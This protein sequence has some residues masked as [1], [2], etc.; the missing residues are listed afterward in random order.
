MQKPN[1][2]GWFF[3]KIFFQNRKKYDWSFGEEGVAVV[4]GW[5]VSVG[6]VNVLNIHTLTNNFGVFR[7]HFEFRILHI[8]AQ[9]IW[10]KQLSNLSLKN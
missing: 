10:R 9:K 3:T 1:R 2:Y 4:V 6:S 8:Y 7:R 5:F